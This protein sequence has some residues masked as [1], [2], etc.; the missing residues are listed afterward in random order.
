MR[1]DTEAEVGV[2]IK[3]VASPVEGGTSRSFRRIGSSSDKMPHLSRPTGRGSVAGPASGGKVRQYRVHGNLLD[4]G[5]GGADARLSARGQDDLADMLARFHQ[6][7][8]LRR[9]GKGKGECYRRN[10]AIGNQ[11]ANAFLRRGRS[12]L[13]GDGAWPQTGAGDRQC[14]L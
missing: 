4:S 2:L 1:Q 7:M 5:A 11:L 12:R 10:A 6:A 8:C 13:L 9:L 14:R 3:Q